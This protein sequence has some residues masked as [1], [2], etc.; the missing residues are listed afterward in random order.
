MPMRT[1]LE[2]SV[3]VKV[4]LQQ[5]GKNRHTATGGMEVRYYTVKPST[6]FGPIWGQSSKVSR[7]RLRIEIIG[8][9]SENQELHEPITI[10]QSLFHQHNVNK[11][12]EMLNIH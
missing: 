1:I 4:P 2:N 12:L 9:Y 11:L 5:A 7:N 6:Y 8:S 10:F 3:T